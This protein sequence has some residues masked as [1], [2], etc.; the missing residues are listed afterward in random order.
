MAQRRDQTSFLSRIIS[1][2]LIIV[3]RE[4][5]ITPVTD[6]EMMHREMPGSRL[7]IIENAGHVSNMEQPAEFNRVVLKFLHDLGG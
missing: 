2:T 4:D 3:G 7:E 5:S 6:A 1:P